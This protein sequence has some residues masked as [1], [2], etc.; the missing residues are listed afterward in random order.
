MSTISAGPFA[1]LERAAAVPSTTPLTSR[2]AGR[3]FPR[4]SRAADR[5]EAEPAPADRATLAQPPEQR[6]GVV[7]G[8][9]VGLAPHLPAPPPEG[10]GVHA[11]HGLVE[12]DE[13]APGVAGVQRGVG[14]DHVRISLEVGVLR[15]V[16]GRHGQRDGAHGGLELVASR[17]RWPGSPWPPRCRLGADRAGSPGPPSSGPCGRP[18]SAPRGRRTATRPPPRPGA[19][20][21]P[22]PPE[23]SAR[24]PGRGRWSRRGR[25]ARRAPSRCRSPSGGRRCPRAPTRWT[26]AAPGPRR[27]PSAAASAPLRSAPR[28]GAAP[29]PWP[30]PRRRRRA[31]TVARRAVRSSFMRCTTDGCR[32]AGPPGRPA[33]PRARCRRPGS[34]P[35]LGGSPG[36]GS[37]A[38]P[39]T[40]R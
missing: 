24:G 33:R 21:P 29:P 11:H 39:R 37:A 40:C 14:L 19:A 27:A 35:R 20:A 34:P 9:G 25:R 10:H 31:V 30:P 12:A 15:G 8:D 4:C 38:R 5:P 17:R 16:E 36:S 23:S 32:L 3:S 28:S 2:P 1:R 22:R 6:P 26:A 18:P 13:R 7:H